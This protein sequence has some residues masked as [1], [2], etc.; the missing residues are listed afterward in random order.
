MSRHCAL[1]WDFRF[2]SSS[3]GTASSSS[4]YGNS[5]VLPKTESQAPSPVSPYAVSKLAG[6]Y[7]CQVFTKVFGLETVILRYFNV[8]GPRQDP[9]S[10]YA[11]VVP[12]FI[13]L[14]LDGEPLQIHGDGLQ[15][16]EPQNDV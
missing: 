5:E 8:F 7:Y 15:S 9:S 14:A 10:Q 2:C 11:A 12:R 1:S 16:R 6:E 13:Q 4:V 3:P